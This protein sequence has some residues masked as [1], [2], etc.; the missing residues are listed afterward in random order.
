[1]VK[2]GLSLGYLALGF[3]QTW[4]GKVC[5]RTVSLEGLTVEN[6]FSSSVAAEDRFKSHTG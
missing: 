2:D 6:S 4:V 3:E 1:M 5:W